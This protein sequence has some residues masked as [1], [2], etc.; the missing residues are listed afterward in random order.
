MVEVVE[1]EEGDSSGSDSSKSEM[2]SP[3][4]LVELIRLKILLPP[5]FSLM[6]IMS[7]L[8]CKLLTSVLGECCNLMMTFIRVHCEDRDGV[9]GE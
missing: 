6:L 3:I 4:L 9:W 7:F 1:E 8:N 5:F 2:D